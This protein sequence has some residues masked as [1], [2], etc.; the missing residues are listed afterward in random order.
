[1][2]VPGLGVKSELQPQQHRIWA[3]SVTYTIA[4]GNASSLTNERVQRSNSHLHGHYVKFLTHWATTGA[5]DVRIR[6][7]QTL[8]QWTQQPALIHF[9]IK[10]NNSSHYNT[11][12]IVWI[13]YTHG[14]T[15]S[16]GTAMK[17][18]GSQTGGLQ[19]PSKHL[20]GSGKLYLCPK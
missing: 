19:P 4:H 7:D 16:T 3:V 10:V 11:N 20:L 8:K 6:L 9:I 14:Q 2:D 13:V 17:R 5:P 1:M 15:K 18:R 12:I